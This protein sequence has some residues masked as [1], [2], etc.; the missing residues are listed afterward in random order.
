[1]KLTTILTNWEQ[2]FQI[3]RRF[4]LPFVYRGHGNSVWELETSIERTIKKY[5]TPPF[6][7]DYTSDEKWMLY[8]FIRK[9]H[10]YHEYGIRHDDK[11]EWLA[12]MQ[13]YGS[14]TRLLDFTYSF[15]I[16]S[17]FAIIE[18]TDDASI[19]AVNKYI[20]RDNLHEDFKLPYEKGVALLDEVNIKHIEF[21]NK[22]IAKAY[23]SNYKYPDTVIP[24]E[25]KLLNERLSKQQ[26]LF[27]MPTNPR[28]SFQQ[29]LISSLKINDLELEPIS[30]ENLIE[31]SNVKDNKVELVKFVIPKE[32]HNKIIKHL[33][34]MNI[35]YENLFP[36]LEG[37]AKTLIQQK[38]RK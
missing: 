38:I 6:F 15:Y 27:L 22:F 25:P 32:N 5:R 14:P 31:L 13:H 36:G 28:K 29:N 4:L 37:L 16:A 21:A 10:L 19:W 20:I 2:F 3:N 33:N 34:E 7:D 35:T 11:F 24:L 30:I 8:E 9:A 23:E 18:S 12:I 1:M 26:G 17:F